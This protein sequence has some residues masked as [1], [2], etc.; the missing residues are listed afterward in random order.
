MGCYAVIQSDYKKFVKISKMH[1]TM[2]TE[3]R[4]IPPFC[5]PSVLLSR[6]V[7]FHLIAL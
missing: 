5:I 3:R 1:I 7:P 6:K 2:L 4:K